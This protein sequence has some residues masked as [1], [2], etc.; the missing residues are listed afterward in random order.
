MTAEA[1]IERLR[2]AVDEHDLDGVVAAFAPDYRNQTPVH[3]GRGFVGRDQVRA[4][5]ERIFAGLPDVV[6]SVLRI[7][8]ED[9][10][11]WTEWELRGHRPDGVPQMLRGVIIFGVVGEQI[12]WAR[13]YL[14]PVDSGE[15]GV[16]AAVRRIAGTQ[17]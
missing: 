17:G 16:D 13:F 3:P 2:R 14:E 12:T 15:D 10:G 8:V 5:W 11:A 7:T 1:V 4:N 9:D 6:A